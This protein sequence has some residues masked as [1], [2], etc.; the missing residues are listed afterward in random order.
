MA[1]TDFSRELGTRTLALAYLRD[2]KKVS[3]EAFEAIMCF[4]ILETPRLEALRRN[5]DQREWYFLAEQLRAFANMRHEE[6][7]YLV[8]GDASREALRSEGQLIEL[9][10]ALAGVAGSMNRNAPEIGR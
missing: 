9:L 8:T 2:E 6:L 5:F 10:R 7:L 3:F 1:T 4:H